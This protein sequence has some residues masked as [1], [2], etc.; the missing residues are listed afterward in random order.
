MKITP[1]SDLCINVHA[2]RLAK[3]PHEWVLTSIFADDYPP[4][5]GPG[6][7]YS[8]G[9]HPAHIESCDVRLMLKKI[10]LST[11][12]PLVLAIGE[13]GLDRMVSA[14]LELQIRVFEAQVEIA[15]QAGIPVIIHAVRSFNELIGFSKHHRPSV[16]MIIHG[17]RGSVQMASDLVREGFYL[18]FGAA[19]LKDPRNADAARTIPYEKLFLETDE[20]EADI[21]QIYQRMAAIRRIT[22]A[23][24]KHEM[25]KNA[26]AVFHR[27]ETGFS[28]GSQHI[29]PSED[30]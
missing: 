28:G 22:M 17:Y 9:L 3:G 23:E 5:D 21:L 6:A 13:A 1:E 27:D 26:L 20:D 24:L 19:L 10:Q 4:L 7:Y 11:E 16:P 25:I 2:H 8:V 14:P 15:E 30:E 18:S 29:E 12:N